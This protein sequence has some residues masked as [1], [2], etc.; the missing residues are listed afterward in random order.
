MEEAYNVED[1]IIINNKE[2]CIIKKYN[3]CY[4]IIS[5][6]VP[7]D[8]KVGK[9]NKNEFVVINDQDKI[10]EVLLSK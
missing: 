2:Y 3:D 8:I 7:L 10:K 1:I 4:L 9:F 5:I 6:D